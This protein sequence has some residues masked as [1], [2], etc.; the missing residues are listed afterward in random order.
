[1]TRP[2]PAE[3]RDEMSQDPFYQKCCVADGTCQG[4]IQ[5]HH[6]LIYASKRQNVGILPV[7]E[8][9]HRI[10]ASIKDKLDWVMLNRMSDSELKQFSKAVN[11]KDRRDRLNKTYGNT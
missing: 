2:I 1:M 7:C 5:W 10:E 9:H 4:V 3:Q 8:Y 6:N 11:L